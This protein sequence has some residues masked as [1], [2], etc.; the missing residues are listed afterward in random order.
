MK[1]TR[2]K[3]ILMLLVPV[4]LVLHGFSYYHVESIRNSIRYKDTIDAPMLPN[5]VMKMAAGEFKGVVADFLVLE[6]GAFIDSGRDKSEADWDRI[7]FHFSQVMALDP[8]FAQTY[9]LI[10]AYL[11]ASGRVETANELLEIARRHL[12][13]DW[14]PGFFIGFNAFN[15]LK[16]YA[17]AS[18]YLIEASKIKGAPPIL[19]TLGSRL[20]QKSGQTV[21]ALGFLKTMYANP[22]YD[23]EAKKLIATR[24]QTLESVLILERAMA[25]YEQRFG[26]P[27][28]MLEDLVRSGILKQIPVHGELGSFGYSGGRITY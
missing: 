18:E 22:D 15:D 12:P 11:P 3:T 25:L 5:A 14:Y 10:Q 16:D 28:T 21:T 7:A 24:I 9:R 8:Y 26:K 23:D 2:T 6:L 27:I 17:K 13:W 20:A 19:A 4:L 1:N